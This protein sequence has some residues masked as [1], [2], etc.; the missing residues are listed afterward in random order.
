M[1]TNLRQIMNAQM[2]PAIVG[3]WQ[4]EKGYIPCRIFKNISYGAMGITNSYH[5][6][7]LFNENIVYDDNSRVLFNK[8]NEA[9]KSYTLEDQFALM[10]FVRDNHTYVNRINTILECLKLIK[11]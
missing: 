3:K 5:V 4:Q 11:E 8:A 9:L 7:K 1:K 2:A 10:D 6:Y